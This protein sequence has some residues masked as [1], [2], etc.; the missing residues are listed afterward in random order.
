MRQRR[1][2]L[3]LRKI[4]AVRKTPESEFATLGCEKQTRPSTS[5]GAQTRFSLIFDARTQIPGGVFL[6]ADTDLK[7][8]YT[9]SSLSRRCYLAGICRHASI[10]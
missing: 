4:K 2:S 10:R 3:W 9:F 8:A 7:T 6:K 5:L 1:I